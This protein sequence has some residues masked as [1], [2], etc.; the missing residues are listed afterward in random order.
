MLP[1]LE[2]T[3]RTLF[4]REL[5]P[6]PARAEDNGV[7]RKLHALPWKGNG[8]VR[9]ICGQTRCGARVRDGWG[10]SAGHRRVLE[11]LQGLSAISKDEVIVTGVDYTYQFDLTAWGWTHLVLG[12]IVTAAGIALFTGATWA[13]GGAW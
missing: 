9:G 7:R 6:S 1:V 11:L 5:P 3:R 2:T 10:G 13:R 4:C 12:A 8:H